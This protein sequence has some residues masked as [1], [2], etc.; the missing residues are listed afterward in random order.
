MKWL[1]VLYLIALAV[2]LG[3]MA[4]LVL[5]PITPD[6]SLQAA[7]ED[8]NAPPEAGRA[9]K[10]HEM[11]ANLKRALETGSPEHCSSGGIGQ[12]ICVELAEFAGQY[13][14]GGSAM[15]KT[16][17]IAFLKEKKE[18]CEWIDLNWYSLTCIAIIEKDFSGCNRIGYEKNR[19]LCISELARNLGGM[20]CDFNEIDWQ[21]FCIA[22]AD[23]NLQE[24][25]SIGQSRLREQCQEIL[26][27]ET[28]AQR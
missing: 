5:N 20:G 21:L 4:F 2:V 16:F 22:Q 9:E 7:M 27:K 28:G 23:F 12:E 19:A 17:C 3:L 13:C 15:E 24:C 11:P 8:R 18:Y 1:L 26:A 14:G 6:S 10:K 25:S